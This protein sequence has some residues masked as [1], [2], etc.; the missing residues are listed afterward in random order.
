MSFALKLG[1]AYMGLTIV[2]GLLFFAWACFSF[3]R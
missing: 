2:G 3:V 1:V